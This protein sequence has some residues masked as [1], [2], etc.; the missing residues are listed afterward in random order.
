MKAAILGFG[1]PMPIKL[2]LLTAKILRAA[3]PDETRDNGG[4]GE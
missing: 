3:M 2:E 4:F 1:S